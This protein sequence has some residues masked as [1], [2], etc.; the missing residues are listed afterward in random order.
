MSGNKSSCT[1][2]CLVCNRP[3][4]SQ[5]ALSVH[6]LKSSYCMEM[7]N[8]TT[9]ATKY[10]TS[11]FHPY[12]LTVAKYHTTEDLQSPKKQKITQKLLEA[13]LSINNSIDVTNNDNNIEVA[14]DN[15]HNAE[16]CETG[17]F[18][19]NQGV[20]CLQSSGLVHEIILLRLLNKLGTPLY[21][22]SK[23]MDWAKTAS[24]SQFNFDTNNKTYHQV[25]NKLESLLGMQ[26]F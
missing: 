20:N 1:F 7:G 19:N 18:C 8:N 25:I 23:I 5:R 17:S 2:T 16:E 22:Y 11:C 15:D 12:N 4:A 14:G 3:F 13:Y 6:V 10:N 24:I 26:P 9:M 21:A